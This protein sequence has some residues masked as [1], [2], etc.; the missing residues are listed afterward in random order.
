MG[1]RQIGDAGENHL[2]AAAIKYH[3]IVLEHSHPH[4][5]VMSHPGAIAEEIF[6][7][8]GNNVHTVCGAQVTQR[9]HVRASR[10]EAAV[11]QVPCYHDQVRAEVIRPLDNGTRPFRGEEAADVEIGQ[12]QQRVTIEL[13]CQ[14]PN[15]DLDVLQRRHPQRLM[16]T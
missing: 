9:L 14:S 16:D 8:A 5:S 6:V 11:D 12:L 1:R 10:R 4:F 13:R 3:V 7:V 2:A 15:A